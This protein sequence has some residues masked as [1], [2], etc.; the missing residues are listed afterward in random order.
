[1]GQV[2]R[3]P[4]YVFVFHRI[5]LDFLRGVLDARPSS[6]MDVYRRDGIA[7]GAASSLI[8]SLSLLVVVLSERALEEVY[9]KPGAAH[10]CY[11]SDAGEHDTLTGKEKTRFCETWGE[12]EKGNLVCGTCKNENR[13]APWELRAHVTN[14]ASR[15]GKGS[16]GYQA[17]SGCPCVGSSHATKRK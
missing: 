3:M 9:E 2:L 1:M 6:R 4:S 16:A 14:R 11:I 15:W 8:R 7:V 17:L 5:A 13:R 10:G 12:P